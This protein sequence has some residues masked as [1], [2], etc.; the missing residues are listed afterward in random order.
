M[1]ATCAREMRRC[2]SLGDLRQASR[3][4]SAR[5][6]AVGVIRP[7]R[8]QPRRAKPSPH[9][10]PGGRSRRPASHWPPSRR[11]RRRRAMPCNRVSGCSAKANMC[12][13]IRNVR[14]LRRPGMRPSSRD[15][16]LGCGHGAANTDLVP[17]GGDDGDSGRSTQG[18]GRWYPR[19]HS[20]A[21]CGCDRRRGAPDDLVIQDWR[22]IHP[23]RSTNKRSAALDGADLV[24]V[25][26]LCSLP[27]NLD[28]GARSRIAAEHSGRVLP[29]PRP[30][31]AAGKLQHLEAS[32]AAFRA[33]CTPRSTC[34]AAASYTR[35]ATKTR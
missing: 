34:A 10:S 1:T 15:I 6:Y 9:Q 16:P 17:P 11:A 2:E 30:A 7:S 24:V 21:R 13:S 4:A 20:P 18:P 31:L 3:R 14:Q 27:L 29:S 23:S 22:S 8:S 12:S 26:N 19:L 33:R 28:G 32:S 35:A 25:D 5:A